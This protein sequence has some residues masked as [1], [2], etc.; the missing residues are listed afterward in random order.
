MVQMKVGEEYGVYLLRVDI[1][2]GQVGHELALPP[3]DGFD[4]ARAVAGVNE[5]RL[6]LGTDQVAPDLDEHVVLYETRRD[7]VPCRA[8]KPPATAPGKAG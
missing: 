2:G 4:G 7:S 1:L 3:P 6:S 5:N 8:P